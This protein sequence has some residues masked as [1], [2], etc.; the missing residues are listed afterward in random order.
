MIS[1]A[2]RKN[3]AL[4]IS[5]V[6]WVSIDGPKGNSSKPDFSY[7]WV[8]VSEQG[9]FVRAIDENGTKLDEFTIDPAGIFQELYRAPEL[10]DF[11]FS[12]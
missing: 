1:R 2:P 6:N 7:L 8:K 5:P 10:K 3:P 9:I 11:P 4:K 12:E